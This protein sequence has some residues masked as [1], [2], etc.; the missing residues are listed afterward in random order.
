[1]RSYSP[2]AE[3]KKEDEQK[4]SFVLNVP[5]KNESNPEQNAEEEAVMVTPE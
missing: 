2:P 3:A 4:S 5:Q 1:M